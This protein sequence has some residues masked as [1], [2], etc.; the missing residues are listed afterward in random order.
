[1]AETVRTL[2]DV[3]TQIPVGVAD[4]TSAQDIRDF[5][6]S[7]MGR[8]AYRAE[9]ATYTVTEYD[10]FV[11]MSASG[12]ARTVNLP[13]VATTRVGKIVIIRKSDTSAN[14]VTIDANSS[15]TI[16]GETTQV[17]FTF[18]S[19]VALRNTGTLWQITSQRGVMSGSIFA[20][21]ASAAAVASS[22]AETTILSTGN[23]TKTLPANFFR[24]GRTIR[25]KVWGVIGNTG[26]PNITI[27]VK[28]GSTVILTSGTVAS[29][30]V[31]AN[32][33]FELTADI[34][35]RTV[36]GSGT[37]MAQGAFY[38]GPNRLQ[39]PAT[40]TVTVDTT[41]SQAL[42]VTAQWGTN[43]PANTITGH[44]CSVEIVA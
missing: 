29:I 3:L 11:N 22:T 5:A 27:K 12:G 41:A 6:W 13:A 33:G 34:I 28:L 4:G 42:D 14:A 40:A 37:V 25:V 24:I 21:T 31:A 20:Q 35:C 18:G 1:M 32:S 38:Y 9:T 8:G 23:G 19:F 15:E 10:E 36:G 17:L 39:L 44:M 43:D 30:S 2:D 7:A 26:T 16:E